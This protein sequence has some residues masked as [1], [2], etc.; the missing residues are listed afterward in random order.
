MNEPSAASQAD[1]ASWLDEHGDALFR[2]ARL[3]VRDQNIAEDLVQDTF[4]SALRAYESFQHRSSIR[5]WLIGILRNKIIDHFRKAGRAMSADETAFDKKAVDDFFDETDHWRVPP[6]DWGTEPN[7]S[8]ENREF[9]NTFESCVLKLPRTLVDAFC[10]RDL[11]ACEAEE[12]CRVLDVSESNLS[13]R[14]YRARM[15]LRKCLE[16]NWF[17]PDA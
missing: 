5:T 17:L 8:A 10:L 7:L 2:F 12:V 11:Y 6:G 13:V 9:W 1:P 15:L 4:L 3:R 14:T 16:F